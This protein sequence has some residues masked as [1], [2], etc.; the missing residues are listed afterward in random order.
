MKELEITFLSVNRHGPAQ[1]VRAAVFLPDV[2]TD[3]TG[4]MLFC[5]GWGG[6]R[7]QHL[8]K[9]HFSCDKFDLVCIAP[10]YR[11]SGYAFDPEG[12][13]GWSQPYDLS[14][15]QTFDCINALRTVL[16]MYGNLNRKRLFA[17]GGSQGGHI[18]LLSAV[19]APSTFAFVYGSCPLTHVEEEGEPLYGYEERS[20]TAAEK[21]VRNVL[22]HASLIRCPVFLEAGTADG[23]VPHF[24][25]AAKLEAKLKELGKTVKAVYYEGGGHDLSPTTNKLEAYKK[26]I[27]SALET[28]LNPETDDFA[29]G[30]SIR[31]PCAD[32]VLVIDWAKAPESPE[33]FRWE[34]A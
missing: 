24:L 27:P 14:F 6:N 3:H 18:V 33:L 15:L 19:F 26:M 30:R 28:L 31:I 13:S 17:Y 10:E 1:K 4:A 2:M 23:S 5:H 9:M 22:E 16:G 12:G 32:K 20:F 34:K 7:K 8:D 25:H 21:S 29:A 11:M